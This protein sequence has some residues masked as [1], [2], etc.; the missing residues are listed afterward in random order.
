MIQYGSEAIDENRKIVNPEY[1]KINHKIKELA[2]KIQRKEAKF[3]KV[4]E[5]INEEDI[6]EIPTLTRYQI[7]SMGNIIALKKEREALITERSKMQSK[8]MLKEMPDVTRLNK[9]KPE[10]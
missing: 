7:Q 2:E 9:L 3:Y 1:R 8:I 10:K 4:A 5:Q 6:D